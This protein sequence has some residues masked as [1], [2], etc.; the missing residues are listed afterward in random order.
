MWQSSGCPAFKPTGCPVLKN[1]NSDCPFLKKGK[2][3]T[4]K[5]KALKAGCP[6]FRKDTGCPYFFK[7]GACPLKAGVR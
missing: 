6:F 7:T 2:G 3:C 5:D 1:N 4:V